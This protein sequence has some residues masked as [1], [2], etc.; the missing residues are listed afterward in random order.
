MPKW[1]CSNNNTQYKWFEPPQSTHDVHKA[2][3]QDVC[4]CESQLELE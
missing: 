2:M 3:R 4:T 1:V